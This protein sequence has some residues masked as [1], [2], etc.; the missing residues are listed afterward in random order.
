MR[1]WGMPILVIAIMAGTAL[2]LMLLPV[3]AEEED[4]GKSAIA[5]MT[6]AK[7][8]HEELKEKCHEE[9]R[10]EMVFSAIPGTAALVAAVVSVALLRGEPASEA[11]A[12]E[13]GEH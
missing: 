3:K 1:R 11:A 10:K 2:A 5:I 6:G 12:E 9:A 7:V 13:G 8:H 4:C